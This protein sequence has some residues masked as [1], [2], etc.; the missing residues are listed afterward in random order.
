MPRKQTTEDTKAAPVKKSS[1]AKKS[2]MAA[3][4]KAPAKRT[5]KAEPIFNLEAHRE[6]IARQAYHF[7]LERGGAHGGAAEDW[8]RAETEIRRRWEQALRA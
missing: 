6:E 8:S 4:H 1:A 3:T 5:V 7:W 2:V